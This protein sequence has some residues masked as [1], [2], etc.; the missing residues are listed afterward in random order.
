[1]TEISAKFFSSMIQESGDEPP[2]KQWADQRQAEW[3]KECANRAALLE[4][5][6]L[7]RDWVAC[8]SWINQWQAEGEASA[9]ILA[10][11][12]ADSSPRPNSNE[13]ILR[14]LK[15]S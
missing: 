9:D 8:R 1:M 14:R 5:L 4:S 12:G 13:R 10:G 3:E 15:P 7:R 11:S 2:N 6:M